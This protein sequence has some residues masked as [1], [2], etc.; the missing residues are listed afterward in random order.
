MAETGVLTMAL[1][2]L[3]RCRWVQCRKAVTKALCKA[4]SPL[5]CLSRAVINKWFSAVPR[6]PWSTVCPE[7]P[8]QNCKQRPQAPISHRARR[9]LVCVWERAIRATF[10]RWAVTCME[11]C[12]LVYHILRTAAL[13]RD[14]PLL[15][16]G[17]LQQWDSIH[18]TSLEKH[19]LPSCDLETE[20]ALVLFDP[21]THLT[22]RDTFLCP[23]WPQGAGSCLGGLSLGERPVVALLFASCQTLTRFPVTTTWFLTNTYHRTLA[24]LLFQKE[25]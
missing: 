9:H 12:G 20:L 3:H 19:R 22:L 15:P 7:A 24:F 4:S 23:R 21:Q 10:L 25:G 5:T 1:I 17:L 13:R 8:L 14:D 11:V 6:C 16:P 2:L 18:A